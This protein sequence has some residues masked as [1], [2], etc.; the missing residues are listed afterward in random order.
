MHTSFGTFNLS[1]FQRDGFVSVYYPIYIFRNVF[2]PPEI[3]PIEYSEY[4][5]LK[6]KT[7]RSLKYLQ[8]V[9]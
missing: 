8:K 7:S 5:N 6:Y 9:F 4:P 1:L 2:F 3:T